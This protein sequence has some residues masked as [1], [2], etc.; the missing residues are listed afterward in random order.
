[1]GYIVAIRFLD[2]YIFFIF[3][4]PLSTIC[5]RSRKTGNVAH[6][7]SNGMMALIELPKAKM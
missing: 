1:M 6:V 7:V 5:E 4:I 2:F 3:T